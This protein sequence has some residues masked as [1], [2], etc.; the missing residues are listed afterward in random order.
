MFPPVSAAAVLLVGY[1]VDKGLLS[2]KP[3]WLI[4]N[5]SAKPEI[6]VLDLIL[7][8]PSPQLGE[9]LGGGRLLPHDPWQGQVRGH[10]AGDLSSAGAVNTLRAPPPPPPTQWT[11]GQD[12]T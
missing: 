6:P 11:G 8:P 1:G 5:R 4:K 9:E 2:T 12:W 7:P 3:Y 10:G